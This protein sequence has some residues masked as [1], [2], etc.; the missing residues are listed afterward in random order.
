[1]TSA[2]ERKAVFAQLEDLERG[3]R[4]VLTSL[5]AKTTASEAIDQAITALVDLPFDA[6]ATIRAFQDGPESEL[7]LAKTKL[8]RVADLDAVVRSECARLLAATAYAIERARVLGS[9]LDGI[10]GEDSTGDSVDCV[11]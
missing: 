5:E 11:R 2:V 3:L 7:A 6:Q 4:S 10:S 8:T 9:G 1:M